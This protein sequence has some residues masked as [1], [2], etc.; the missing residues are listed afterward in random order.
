MSNF[1]LDGLLTN[2]FE[3]FAKRKAKTSDACV[4]TLDKAT[5]EGLYRNNRLIQKVVNLLPEDAAIKPPII[6]F[7]GDAKIDGDAVWQYLKKIG[8]LHAFTMAGKLG[9]LYG[10]GYII[11][12]VDDGRDYWEPVD[13]TRIKSVSILGVKPRYYLYQDGLNSDYYQL[14]TDSI[15]PITDKNGQKLGSV[16]IHKGRVL[17]IAGVSLPCE[18][19]A[20]NSYHNDSVIQAMFTEFV[21]YTN[22]VAMG[23]SMLASHSLFKYKLKDL[24]Q[25]VNQKQQTQLVARFESMLMGLSA[26]NGLIVDADREDAEFITRNYAGIDTLLQHLQEVLIAV[27]DYPRSKLLGSS[28]SSAFSEGGL[29]DRYEWANKVENYQN[30]YWLSEMETLVRYV[31]LSKDSPTKGI[32]PESWSIL[33]PTI[34][35]LTLKEQ[36][37]LRLIVAQTDQINFSNGF[38]TQNEVRQSRF[39]GAEFGFEITLQD[40]SK[41]SLL[42]NGMPRSEY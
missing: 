26:M 41:D 12:G 27:S 14:T 33:F 13:E 31:L 39:G 29:S 23:A 1:F 22:S 21:S 10:D 36:A 8:T 35:Q 3:G 24:A 18:V 32:L 11:L 34:L 20:N 2:V 40:A 15:N 4:Y 7:G 42:I 17:R 16:R 6:S 5:L 38:I 9:R 28:N 19:R 37:E 30:N 25:L